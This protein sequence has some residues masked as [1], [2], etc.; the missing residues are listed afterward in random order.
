MEPNSPDCDGGGFRTTGS[1]KTESTAW[2]SLMSLLTTL[3]KTA[4]IIFLSMP[5]S[6]TRCEDLAK[7]TIP[8]VS[9]TL[10]SHVAAGHFRPPA[11]DKILDTPAFC[12][13]V[14]I[15]KPTSDSLINFE[16]WIPT[17]EDRLGS[18]RADIMVSGLPTIRK[19]ATV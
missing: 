16:V 3:T 5:A 8:G 4:V 2:N 11:S 10:A 9:V 17:V 12:R 7:L 18:C 14:A 13:V 6:A 15:A 19:R 1:S